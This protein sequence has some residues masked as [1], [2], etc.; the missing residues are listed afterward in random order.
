MAL[1]GAVA[2][3]G[4]LAFDLCDIGLVLID[5][6]LQRLDVALGLFIGFG[7]LVDL[8]LR[9]VEFGLRFARDRIR[10]F[11]GESGCCGERDGERGAREQARRARGDERDMRASDTHKPP[12]GQWF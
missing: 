7:G 11:R 3:T 2:L 9:L 8:L 6:L 4:K 1:G 5:E 12:Q 10:R